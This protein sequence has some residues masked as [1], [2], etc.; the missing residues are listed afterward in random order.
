MLAQHSA[1]VS[2]EQKEPEGLSE[3]GGGHAGPCEAIASSPPLGR[4]H[5]P[6]P[7]RLQGWDACDPSVKSASLASTT[8]RGGAVT[9]VRTGLA[10]GLRITA[11]ACQTCLSE[12]SG[13]GFIF[14]KEVFFVLFCFSISFFIWLSWVFSA[15]CGL[16]LAAVSRATLRCSAQPSHCRDP[17]RCRAQALGCLAFR[18][19]GMWT[20]LP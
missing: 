11:I 6:C 4:S 12:R 16:S 2:S 15:V 10:V 1:G 7:A 18:S 3:S 17:P 19:C 8:Y 14:F 5:L 20:Q 9:S 13:V